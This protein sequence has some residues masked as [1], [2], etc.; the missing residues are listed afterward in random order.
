MSLRTQGWYLLDVDSVA[1]K[2]CVHAVYF[3]VVH[4]RSF[5]RQIHHSTTARTSSNIIIRFGVA[6]Q[7]A[8]ATNISASVIAAIIC[9]VVF[10]VLRFK[11]SQSI[12]LRE[13]RR[14]KQRKGSFK[15]IH[16]QVKIKNLYYRIL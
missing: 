11:C 7:N 6:H 5:S 4:G 16:E 2:D 8:S 3:V 14:G 1:T 10:C 9:C 12:R 13:E 15:K